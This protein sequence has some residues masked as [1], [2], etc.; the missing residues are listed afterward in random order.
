MSERKAW[1]APES[2]G[3]SGLPA[4]QWKAALPVLGK[5]SQALTQR[6]TIPE[7]NCNEKRSPQDRPFL[8]MRTRPWGA[9]SV[10]VAVVRLPHGPLASLGRIRVVWGSC[11]C[12]IQPELE[13]N[14]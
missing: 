2:P 12:L 9:P 13:A 1:A 10:T 4:S 8:A 11:N 5:V 14:G 6:L 3:L 7:K